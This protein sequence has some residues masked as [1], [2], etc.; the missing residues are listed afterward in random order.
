MPATAVTSIKPISGRI[1]Y[2][3][4]WYGPGRRAH[5]GTILDAGRKRLP[6]ALKDLLK[7]AAD[8]LYPVIVR[9]TALSLLA[10]YP[11]RR[12]HAEAYELALMDEEALIRRTAVDHLN[13]T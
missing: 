9:S 4:K 11:G 13:G 7:L 5:Y 10:A 1:E 3:T 6:E 2:I 8:P 12:D